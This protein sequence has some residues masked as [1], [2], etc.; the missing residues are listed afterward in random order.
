MQNQLKWTITFLS[1]VGVFV[2]SYSAGT[3]M[4]HARAPD[5][6]SASPNQER[7]AEQTYRNIQ[8]FKGL[9]ES[10]LLAAMQ[11]MAASLGVGCQHCHTNQFAQD[12]KPA[13]QTARRMIAMMRSINQGNFSNKLAINC[14]TC[15]R[16]QL[17]P[18]LVL[19]VTSNQ[20]AA[21]ETKSTKSAE[22]KP[23]V[24]QVLDKYLKALGGQTRLDALTTQWMKG[25]VVESAGTNS[26]TTQPLEIYRKA[27]DKMLMKRE[28]AND[29]LVQAF[30]GRIAWRQ[31]K[32]RVG[33]MSGVEE[34]FARRDA[35]FDRDLNL[36]EQ[37]TRMSVIGRERL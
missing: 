30:D 14:Y 31:F 2:I 11:F 37:F 7:T 22:T 17:K 13:K 24:D 4:G 26:P 33:E 29:A 16:G 3:D 1:L 12:E 6:A 15:H 34:A 19:T 28:L 35:R 23:T 21:G 32:G 20:P 18:A 27:P 10:Q 36:K 9:P 8:V 25:V 5:L